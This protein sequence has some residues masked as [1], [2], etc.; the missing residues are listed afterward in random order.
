M[1]RIIY[2]K[3]Q[4]IIKNKKKIEK[5][6]N[7][8]IEN[9]GKEIIIESKP[10]DEYIAE[11]V[12]EALEFGF[13]FSVAMMIKEHSYSFEIINIKDHTNRKDLKRVRARIIG[14][15]GGTLKTLNELTKCYFE[16]KDNFVAIIGDPEHTKNAHEAIILI[17]KGSKQANVYNHLERHQP[18]E[19]HDL[20]LKED[21]KERGKFK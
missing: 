4:R 17:I 21:F 14:K 16:M 13:P 1:K 12:L 5:I 8:K 2:E 7:I 11:K 10:E 9:R 15:D 19:I 3:S 20:G 18:K 6:L